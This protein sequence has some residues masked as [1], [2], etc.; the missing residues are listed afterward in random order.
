MDKKKWQRMDAT[1]Y[2]DHWARESGTYEDQGIYRALAGI[3]PAERTLEIGCGIGLGT[4][5]LGRT[6]PVLSLDNNA[7]L[8]AQAKHSVHNAG[9]GAEL[10]HED[11]FSVSAQAANQIA[12]FAPTGIVCWFAGSHPDDVERRTS[13]SLSPQDRPKQY[14]EN[15]ED[16]LVQPPLCGPTVKWLHLANRV[17]V[18]TS[19][20]PGEIVQAATDDYNEHMF[21][22]TGFRVV[23]VQVFDWEPGEMAYVF[24]KN[25]LFVGGQ[26]KFKVI[27]LLARRP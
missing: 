26:I 11:V 20:P 13:P 16:R 14:R 22:N 6:R 4:M 9:V 27:S 5:H 24:A 21:K 15:I 2:P 7:K 10:L 25:P 23:D 19:A 17:A 3:A 1:S 18:A 12:E 8:I